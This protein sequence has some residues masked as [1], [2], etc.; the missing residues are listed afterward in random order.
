[1]PIQIRCSCGKGLSV[2]DSLAGKKVKCPAC[3]NPVAIPVPLPGSAP[4]YNVTVAEKKPE[5]LDPPSDESEQDPVGDPPVT[6][7]SPAA[8]ASARVRT[9]GM[10]NARDRETGAAHRAGQTRIRQGST[11]DRKRDR[12]MEAHLRALS[13]WDRVLGVLC[14]IGTVWMVGDGVGLSID[15]FSRH[16][17]FVIQVVMFGSSGILLY[18]IGHFLARYR[19]VA[20]IGAGI[21]MAL[22]MLGILAGLV[23]LNSLSDLISILISTAW[24]VAVLWALFNKRAVRICTENYRLLVSRTPRVVPPTFKSPFFWVPLILTAIM[25]VI[26]LLLFSMMVT[27]VR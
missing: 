19:N 1:M 9:V 17:P 26:I 16:L 6:R 22:R 4:P 13:I 10:K 27:I 20:R 2:P 23:E 14:I 24:T 21:V 12:W 11:E 25:L 5:S 7:K 15:S 3:G 18:L 8:R